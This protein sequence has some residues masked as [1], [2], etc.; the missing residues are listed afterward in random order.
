VTHHHHTR[1]RFGCSSYTV[2]RSG[3]KEPSDKNILK[4]SDKKA[5]HKTRR[6]H[7]RNMLITV[8]AKENER[9]PFDITDLDGNSTIIDLRRA[10]L[11]GLDELP[12]WKR[13]VMS[14]FS[15]ISVHFEGYDK[16]A[17]SPEDNYK[18]LS[19]C[20]YP[21]EGFTVVIKGL[22]LWRHPNGDE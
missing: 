2:Y 22:H 14:V 6:P 10:I 17:L 19:E 18:T 8:Q 21:E 12:T 5:K 15:S 13:Y 7:N 20:G 11:K 16:A 9:T 3:I 4:Q 1:R